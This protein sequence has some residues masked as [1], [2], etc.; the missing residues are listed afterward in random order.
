MRRKGAPGGRNAPAES[1]VR[2]TPTLQG[3]NP[4]T[5]LRP[6]VSAAA[7]TPRTW[8]VERSLTLLRVFLLASAAILLAGAV[9]LSSVLSSRLHGQVVGD[10]RMSLTQYV[11]GVLRPELVDGNRVVVR[12]GL[13]QRLVEALGRRRDIVT[14]KVWRVNGVLAWTNRA[15]SRIGHRFELDGNLGVAMKDNRSVAEIE[16]PDTEENRVERN[17]GFGRLLEV[18]APIRNARGRAIGSYEIYADAKRVEH[19]IAR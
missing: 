16:V 4:E 12:R 8:A 1:L 11:D 5:D 10:A 19:A 15:R 17:L 7:I 3:L 2:A 9:L 6:G 13:P 18:Y 14:I